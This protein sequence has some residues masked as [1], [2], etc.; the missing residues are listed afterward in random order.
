LATTSETAKQYFA[1][2]DAHDLDAATALWEPGAIDRMVGEGLN[3]PAPDGV[4]EYFGALFAAFPDFR[5]EILEMTTARERTAVRWCAR[6]T[7]AGPGSFQGFEPNGARIEVEGCD[8]VRVKDGRI[9]GNDAYFDGASLARQLGFLPP[10]GSRAEVR[11]AQLANV[12]TRVRARLSGARE[13][14]PIANGV[15]LVRG[16]FP[17]ATMNV[18]LIA[19]GDGVVV[20]DAGVAQMAASVAMAAASLGGAT[21]VVLGHADC[22]HRGSAPALGAPVFCHPLEVDAAQSASAF[23]PYWDLHK[24]PAYGRPIYGRLLQSWDGGAVTVAGTVQEGDEVAGFTVIELP[25]HAPGLIGLYREVDRLALVSDCFYTI[26]PLTGR[27]RGP[28]IPHP[29]FNFDTPEA[30]RSI[31]KLAELGPASAWPGHAHPVIGDVRERLQG[32]AAAL[33]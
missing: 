30:G 5:F 19:D 13:P 7:F 18:Y 15:W 21:R 16:G 17:L 23:R 29:A 14:E 1:A 3:L 31:A 28:R 10:A 25:G 8:V 2:L 22:D 27:K 26:N 32:A 11:L 9:V 33:P 6:A 24:L 4:R 12:G 20:F